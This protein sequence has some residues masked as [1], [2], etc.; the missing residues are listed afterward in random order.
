M[1]A[2]SGR[3]LL[4]LVFAL[5]EEIACLR[6]C[7]KRSESHSDRLRIFERSRPLGQSDLLVDPEIGDY[8]SSIVVIVHFEDGCAPRNYITHFMPV[9]TLC[10]GLSSHYHSGKGRLIKLT[11]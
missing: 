11:L 8:R 4:G 5:V 10:I 2:Q 6:P 7:N 3:V 9:F 1:L